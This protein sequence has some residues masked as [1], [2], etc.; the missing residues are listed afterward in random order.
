MHYLVSNDQSPKHF[1]VIFVLLENFSMAA[2]TSSLDVLVT[3]ELVAKDIIL[4]KLICST[5]KNTTRIVSDIGIEVVVE[6]A[7][8]RDVMKQFDMLIICGGYRAK[9]TPNPFLQSM[10]K[11]AHKHKLW[12]GGLWNGS[13]YIANEGFLR[14]KEISIHPESLFLLTE[15]YPNV[16]TSDRTYVVDEKLFSCAGPSSSMQMMIDV[17]GRIF[18]TSVKNSIQ[19][20]LACDMLNT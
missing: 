12:M 7:P 2:F 16:I 8:D 9:L 10:V 18:G 20:S 19:V 5:D 13:Y 6:T 3:A 4:E 11:A 14:G 15:N 17:C 1:R